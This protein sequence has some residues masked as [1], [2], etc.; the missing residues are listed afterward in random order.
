MK[1]IFVK[2]SSLIAV[3]IVFSLSAAFANDLSNSTWSETDAS[4]N[5]VSPNGW[6]SGTMLP[7][8]VEPTARAMMGA[9]K[10]W[11][12]HTNATATSSGSANTQTLTYSVAPA[13][14]VAGDTYTFI[15]GFTNTGA[16]TL[17][18][19]AL[20][21]KAIQ[22]GGVALLGGEIVAGNVVSVAYDGTQFQ[23]LHRAINATVRNTGTGMGT[24][25]PYTA[26]YPDNTVY[27]GINYL[28]T[29]S[30]FFPNGTGTFNNPLA[31][32]QLN[33]ATTLTATLNSN[34]P[35][36]T[37]GY[38][39]QGEIGTIQEY[40][41]AALCES[42][43]TIPYLYKQ[44]GTFTATTFVPSVDLTGSSTTYPFGSP[45]TVTKQSLLK[46]GMLLQ[47]D[48]Y[49]LPYYG[50][51]T[52]V[53]TG[54]TVT[55]GGW[56]KQGVSS[57]GTP[58]GAAVYVNPLSHFWAHLPEI[59]LNKLGASS[60]GSFVAPT[61]TPTSGSPTIT[62]VSSMDG[63]RPGLTI[64]GTGIPTNTTII[65]PFTAN[66]FTISQ[67]AT[68]SPGS[69][70]LN[71]SAV[72]NDHGAISEHDVWNRG[73]AFV[74]K[75]ATKVTGGTSTNGSNTVTGLTAIPATVHAGDFVYSANSEIVP[76]SQV[77]QVA[78]STSV[79]LDHPATG[80]N[81]G[82]ITLTFYSSFFEGGMGID[83]ASIGNNANTGYS[84]RG[85][86]SN[87]FFS[88]GAGDVAFLARSDGLAG[89]PNYSFLSDSSV[90]GSQPILGDYGAL[91]DTGAPTFVVTNGVVTA[92][93]QFTAPF[94][95]GSGPAGTNRG[96]ELG[97][98]TVMSPIPTN[99]WNVIEDN[100]AEAGANAGSNFAINR[101]DDSGTVIDTPVQISRATGVVQ[102]ND[103]LTVVGSSAATRF[104]ATGAA[105]V[106]GAGQ[107]S[108]GATTAA[109][110]NC[111]SG[112][113]ITPVA[114]IV[115]NVAGTT[116]YIPYF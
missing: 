59:F 72:P 7:T 97:T 42:V 45:N 79:V 75:T 26:V 34:R 30:V 1:N 10:R 92:K 81:A 50:W 86:F 63:I 70:S 20:G 85:N 4:N 82:G 19:N 116:R 87:G 103:G 12:N 14:Y 106:V 61:G 39:T 46:V 27:P 101:F 25:N 40:G 65:P 36:C 8:E 2:L 111:N 88:H 62:N 32:G 60:A 84:E 78:S 71:I 15:A 48:D 64:S 67:N 90:V 115:V 41:S 91:D 94:L 80:T 83:M 112:G 108:Y 99:R 58:S 38:T 104:I 49:P 53:G 22:S 29:A 66:S 37:N 33:T 44:A 51:I 47:T 68:S 52:N 76:G 89:V 43:D 13:A 17:N 55:V 109:A 110:A 28:D 102:L 105:S 24:Y 31:Y 23:L 74:P 114:C 9:L 35:P 6:K 11:Y 107:L 16:A 5:S 73:P 95:V 113:A 18:V 3:A 54:T 96:L 57:S 21:A 100:V 98:G 69:V 56:F 93:S 77:V